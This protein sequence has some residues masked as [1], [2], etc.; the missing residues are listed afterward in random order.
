VQTI[1]TNGKAFLLDIN[2]ADQA[3]YEES[4]YKNGYINE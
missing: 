3:D 4:Y 2:K 1:S